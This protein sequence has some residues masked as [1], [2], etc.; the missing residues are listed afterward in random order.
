MGEVQ[1]SVESQ[2]RRRRLLLP[3]WGVR[4]RVYEWRSGSP[5]RLHA[6]EGEIGG[7]AED[8]AE[9]TGGETGASLLGQGE[10]GALVHLLEVVHDL[11]VDADTQGASTPTHSFLNLKGI[12]ET[13]F[14]SLL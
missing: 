9:A 12:F 2:R 13:N 8:G 11:G 6:D 7:G 3:L 4:V 14:N 10:G 5:P 1:N